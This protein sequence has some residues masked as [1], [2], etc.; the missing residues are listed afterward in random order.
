MQFSDSTSTK[1]K[2]QSD[3]KWKFVFHDLLNN[4]D[5][6]TTGLK[7]ILF[8]MLKYPGDGVREFVAA[9]PYFCV[10]TMNFCCLTNVLRM[11]KPVYLPKNGYISSGSGYIVTGFFG[12]F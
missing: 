2:K 11:V 9:S 1:Q 7:G 12:V 8:F 3:K 10:R 4:Y 6:T 5:T